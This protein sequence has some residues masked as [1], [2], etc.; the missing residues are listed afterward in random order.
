MQKQPVVVLLGDRLSCFHL[1]CS[2]LWMKLA[3]VASSVM[4]PILFLPL[5]RCDPPFFLSFFLSFFLCVVPRQLTTDTGK[6]WTPTKTS[7]TSQPSSTT[8]TVK[9]RSLLSSCWR[10]IVS[11]PQVSSEGAAAANLTAS[12]LR[13]VSPSFSNSLFL[14]SRWWINSGHWDLVTPVWSFSLKS[15]HFCGYIVFSFSIHGYIL[16]CIVIF[17]WVVS[18]LARLLFLK[19]K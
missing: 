5:Q 17:V 16:L 8:P 2:F 14:C 11:W 12:R 1:L 7:R 10:L 9:W 4:G 13:F 19:H 3:F 6:R 15:F 18:W